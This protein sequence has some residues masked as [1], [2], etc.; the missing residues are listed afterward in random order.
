MLSMTEDYDTALWD[1]LSSCDDS[2]G[3]NIVR[4]REE[5]G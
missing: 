3:S 2:R 4:K 1:W 5:E